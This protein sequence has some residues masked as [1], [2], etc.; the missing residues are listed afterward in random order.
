MA[1]PLPSQ[2]SLEWLRKTAKEHLRE[3]R[4]V[5]PDVTL[6]QAQL[7]VARSYGFPSWRA[8]GRPAAGPARGGRV[9]APRPRR[10]AARG[11]R[12]PERAQ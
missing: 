2:P 7:E 11:G 10:P 12:R 6:A 9:T 3:L 1:M 8:L 4:A 5:G